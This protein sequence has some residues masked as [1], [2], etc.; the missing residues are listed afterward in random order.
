MNQ[1]PPNVNP[2]LFSIAAI[3]V[4]LLIENDYTADELNSIGNWLI[5][6]GQITLTT[7]AQQQL[8]NNRY[9]GNTGS[10]IK[11]GANNHNVFNPTLLTE[12]HIDDL[13]REIYSLRREIEK[14]KRDK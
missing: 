4:G 9:K 8:I 3:I 13:Y 7:S 1:F 10:R 2:E 11:S 12:E 14:I 6:V 5:L